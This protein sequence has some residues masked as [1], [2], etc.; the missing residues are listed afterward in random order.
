MAHDL[1]GRNVLLSNDFYYFGDRPVAM[2]EHLLPIIRRGQGYRSRLNAALV[3]PFEQWIRGL[4]YER[5]RLYGDP[6]DI[7]LLNSVQRT[8]D[9]SSPLRGKRAGRK[10]S[11]APGP[12]RV[13]TC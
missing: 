8:V 3:Q 9:C 1:G 12:S 6:I 13:R 2:P 10:R 4:G 5:N 11:A 7:R